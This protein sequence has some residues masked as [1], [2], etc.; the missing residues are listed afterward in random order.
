MIK[1]L[2]QTKKETLQQIKKDE[3][4]LWG[5][6][7]KVER[8]DWPTYAKAHAVAQ[9]AYG[10]ASYLVGQ[11]DDAVKFLNWAI[12][13]HMPSSSSFPDAYTNLA[14]VY[15]RQKESL[16]P[17]WAEKTEEYLQQAL[18]ISPSNQKAHHQLGS[19]YSDPNVAKY[20][21]PKYD[22]AIEHFKQAG[23]NA[24]SIFFHARILVEQKKELT[25]GI[26]LLLRSLRLKQEPDS[27]YDYLVKT[28]T[29]HGV[30][31]KLPKDLLTAVQE[32]AK[33]MKRGSMNE[34]RWQEHKEFLVVLKLLLAALP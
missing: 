1:D 19:L 31:A 25:Q 10:R 8:A 2:K 6:L 9:N 16:S 7:G 27:R 12:T 22:K 30:N 13:L 4:W 15:L 18:K 23:N 34:E 21:E 24:W 20:D 5:L 33:R 32:L 29:S 14:S 28:L 17:D 26:I 11:D 3:E